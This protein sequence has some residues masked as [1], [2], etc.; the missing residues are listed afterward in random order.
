MGQTQGK[1]RRTTHGSDYDEGH[2]YG[3]GSPPVPGSPL[4]YSPQ[5]PMEPIPR[6]EEHGRGGSVYGQSEFA[7]W[8]AQPKLVPTVIVWAHGGSHVELEGSFDNWTQRYTMQRSGK[9]FTL[10][11]L[12]PPG[13]YQYKFIV[14]GQWRH[15]PNLP[16]MYDDMGN[17]NNVLEVQ[18]YVPENLE[19]LVGFDPPPSPPSSYNSAP[20]AT[21]DFLKEPP[22]MPPQLQLSLLNVPPAMDA[23]AALPRPQHV[24]LNHL[25]LQRMTTSTH[26]MVVGT[27]HRYR[28]KYVTTVMY[29]PKKR[30]QHPTQQPASSDAS[31]HGMVGTPRA[32]QGGTSQTSPMVA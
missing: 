17:I 7:G 12:L 4:I 9:D 26:A 32:S 30:V 19:S 3:R 11:K 5:V 29:K 13:V 1:S 16:S 6:G 8:G 21:E 31:M 23:I 10:V 24:I 14:D 15:D 28:S 22:L 25:Y 2:G 20:P 27:T 18:E